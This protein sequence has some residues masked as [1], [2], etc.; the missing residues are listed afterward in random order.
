[1]RRGEGKNLFWIPNT[2]LGKVSIFGAGEG[3]CPHILQN[4]GSRTPK[5]L[6]DPRFWR[7]RAPDPELKP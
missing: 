1:M 3:T 6:K 7:N 4:H 2:K 5:V